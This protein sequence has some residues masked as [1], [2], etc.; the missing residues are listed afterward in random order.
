[1]SRRSTGGAGML[2]GLDVP[3]VRRDELSLRR[4]WPSHEKSPGSVCLPGPIALT[5]VRSVGFLALDRSPDPL[6]GQVEQNRQHGQEK[7]TDKSG[8]FAGHHLGFRCP[9]QEG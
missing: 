4:R 1:M 2:V 3:A 9:H 8:L 6:V 5:W 7:H